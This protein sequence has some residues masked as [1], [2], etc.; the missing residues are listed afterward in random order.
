MLFK[1][2]T[3]RTTSWRG[4]KPEYR[5]TEILVNLPGGRTYIWTELQGA[6][7]C[8]LS[9]YKPYSPDMPP[10]WFQL[11]S[12]I[13]IPKIPHFCHL[14]PLHSIAFVPTVPP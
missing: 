9:Y 13:P 2:P 7:V 14:D 6:Y 1:C 4:Q 12:T 10:F 11:P 8:F 5:E 3:R